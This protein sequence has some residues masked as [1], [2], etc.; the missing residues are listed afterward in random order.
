MIA[1]D[2]ICMNAEIEIQGTRLVLSDEMP[3]MGSTT[4]ATLGGTT[5]LLDLHVGDA[6]AVFRLAL[7][8]GAKQAY[9]LAD[10]FYGDRA[11]PVR[12]PFGHHWIIATRV[13]EVSEPEMVAAF[14]AMFGA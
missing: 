13:R 11:G 8:A 12:D 9:P 4:P 5:V 10:Q 14:N 3:D 7:E 6:D 1:P 2:G